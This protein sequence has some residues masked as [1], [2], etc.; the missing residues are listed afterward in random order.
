VSEWSLPLLSPFRVA[1]RTAH[2]ASNVLIVISDSEGVVGI[3]SPAPVEYITGETQES[4]VASIEHVSRHLIGLSPVG[5][6]PMISKVAE[7]LPGLPAARAGLEMALYDLWAKRLNLPLWQYFGG[8]TNL[9][10]TDITIP[11][12][13]DLEARSLVSDALADGFRIF[14][15]KIGDSDGHDADFSRIAAVAEVAPRAVLRIDANQAFQPD[16]AVTFV[17]E[18]VRLAPQ[19]EM[20]EQPVPKDDTAGLKY[21]RQRIDRPLYADESARSFREAVNLIECEAVDGI[22]VKL[23]KTGIREAED[24][25]RICKR[26]G[27]GLMVG[28]MLE[29]SLGIAAASAI[30]GGIG[31]FNFID[32]DSHRLLK[33][34]NSLSGGFAAQ[35]ANLKLHPTSSGWGLKYAPLENGTNGT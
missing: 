33:P 18:A 25:I 9:L 8:S 20:V 23:M 21:V 4:T 29:S 28:C 19:I 11:I 12:V 24:I 15:I 5:L 31:G 34:V 2:V 10:T 7:I 26:T 16:A 30:A 13:S 6:L 22:N 32:L 17:N 1:Q 14:K 3:G 35:G 27:T